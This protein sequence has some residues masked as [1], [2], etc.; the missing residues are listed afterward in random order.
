[1]FMAPV[2]R[3]EYD[4]LA[5][6]RRHMLIPS[7]YQQNW[8]EHK[9]KHNLGFTEHETQSVLSQ[10]HFWRGIQLPKEPI[11]AARFVTWC[12]EQSIFARMFDFRRQTIQTDPNLNEIGP[13]GVGLF[14]QSVAEFLSEIPPSI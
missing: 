9:C 14:L 3:Q 1:M 6:L 11:L 12:L 2:G 10:A 5:F 8:L 4:N 13:N 7:K